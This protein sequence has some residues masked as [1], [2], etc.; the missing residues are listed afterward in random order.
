MATFPDTS[1]FN[2]LEVVD[3]RSEIGSIDASGKT[4]DAFLKQRWQFDLESIPL[5]TAQFQSIYPFLVKQNGASGV[6]TFQYPLN[7]IGTAADGYNYNSFTYYTVGAMTKGSTN[8]STQF[9]GSDS[10]SPDGGGVLTLHPHDFVKFANH[11]KIYKITTLN[12]IRMNDYS[13]GGGSGAINIYPAL[14]EDVPSGTTFEIYRPN[15]TFRLLDE[16]SNFE[17]DIDGYYTITMSVLEDY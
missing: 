12:L 14:V 9:I 13:G 10:D 6:F 5:T 8:Y 7:P 17:I 15:F 2:S 1:I 4:Y 3:Q 11:S 16:T